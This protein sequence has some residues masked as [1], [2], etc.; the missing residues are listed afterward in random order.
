MKKVYLGLALLTCFGC[1]SVLHRGKGKTYFSDLLKDVDKVQ[2]KFFNHGDTL[3]ETIT[4]GEQLNVYKVLING[5][6]DAKLKIKCDSTGQLLFFNKENLIL[7]AWFSSPA[8]G[9]KYNQPCVSYSD[10][11]DHFG[12]L[13][14]YQSGISIDDYY[15][16]LRS[17]AIRLS[18]MHQ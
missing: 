11:A 9:S 13:L 2:L 4:D 17:T 8:T 15:Y 3:T 14:T 10:E 6:H 7:N 12:S 5:K 1:N 18:A 16:K